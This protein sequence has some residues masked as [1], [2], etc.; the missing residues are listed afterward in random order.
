MSTITA[1]NSVVTLSIANLYPTPQQ[2]QG[3]SAD[4]AFATGDVETAETV[5]GVDGFMSAGWVPFKTDQTYSIQADSDSRRIFED[6][7]SAQNQQREVYIATGL[8]ILPAIGRQYV[9]TRGVLTKAKQIPDAKKV[10]QA[11]EY[12]ITWAQITPSNI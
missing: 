5:M 11:V 10:L 4:A 8:I 7:L 9:M 2:L 12:T 1:A 6:W 3:Y